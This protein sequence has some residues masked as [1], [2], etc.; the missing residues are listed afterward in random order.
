METCSDFEA[1]LVEAGRM[2]GPVYV[3]QNV[4]RK[5]RTP[6][7]AHRQAAET[8]VLGVDAVLSHTGAACYWGLDPF[9][10]LPPVP[11]C[12]IPMGKWLDNPLV[13]QRR[14]FSHLDLVI[15]GPL[16][17]TTVTQT[18]ADLGAVVDADVVE[19]A[20]ESAIRLGFVTDA[21][22][23]NVVDDP[24]PTWFRTGMA[25]LRNVLAR[26][27]AEAAPTGSDA[28]TVCLQHYRTVPGL[29]EPYRQFPILASDGRLVG[30]GDFGFPPARFFTEVDG[31]GA[32]GSETALAYDL[33]RQ[34]R[35]SDAEYDF[36]RFTAVDVYRRPAYVC[37]ETLT[38]FRLSQLTRGPVR[39]G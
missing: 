36:R 10:G 4:P 18:L 27:P 7:A 5:G 19:R 32:H 1:A 2:A 17:V 20:L 12:S 31:L 26:R 11:E 29:P 16:A 21:Q 6:T 24:H 3:G 33:N 35:A 15:R 13:H 38:G 30:H 34:N 8:L 39:T 14:R 22:L 37:R 9:S 23:R 25:A 28:E